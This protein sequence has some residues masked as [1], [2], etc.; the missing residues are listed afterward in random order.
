[1]REQ[2][3]RVELL[4]EKLKNGSLSLH[5]IRSEPMEVPIQKLDLMESG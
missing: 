2:R 3:S 5:D 4:E 1:M